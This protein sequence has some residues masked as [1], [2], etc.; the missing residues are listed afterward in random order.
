MSAALTALGTTE[1]GDHLLTPAETSKGTSL[2]AK[3]VAITNSNGQATTII[4]Y[5]RAYEDEGTIGGGADGRDTFAIAQ[6][7]KK[8]TLTYKDYASYVGEGAD[9]ILKYR[10]VGASTWSNLGEAT[11]DNSASSTGGDV[12]TYVYNFDLTPAGLSGN[13]EVYAEF[14]KDGEVLATTS[15]VTIY[16]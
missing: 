4:F 6:S 3:F 16:G 8:I 1:D 10:A 5:D 13:Y 9:A 15:S 2:D 14:V 7:A 12:K 11:Y